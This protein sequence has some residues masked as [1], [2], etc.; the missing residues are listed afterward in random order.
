[1]AEKKDAGAAV[2]VQ[3]EQTFTWRT[4]APLVTFRIT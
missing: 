1:M 4:T 3:K 2:A